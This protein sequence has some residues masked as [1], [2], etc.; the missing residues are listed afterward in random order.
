ML[1]SEACLS[2]HSGSRQEVATVAAAD[3]PSVKSDGYDTWKKVS[4][5]SVCALCAPCFVTNSNVPH[6]TKM[7]YNLVIVVVSEFYSI[8][9]VN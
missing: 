9:S 8:L 3:T 5:R 6:S 1:R 7:L 2:A 4:H